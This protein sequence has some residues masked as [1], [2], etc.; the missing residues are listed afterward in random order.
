M[1]ADQTEVPV[2]RPDAD[3]AYRLANMFFLDDGNLALFNL[4]MEVGSGML[5]YEV[6][7]GPA[8]VVEADD[9]D[10]ALAIGMATV[11]P[12]PCWITWVFDDDHADKK[13]FLMGLV[14]GLKSVSQ[15][16]KLLDLERPPNTLAALVACEGSDGRFAYALFR[17]P[18]LD[19]EQARMILLNSF[20]PAEET[21]ET[22][23]PPAD[24]N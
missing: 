2:K 11:G 1:Q 23:G 22:P 18:I 15:P 19:E 9:T 4:V 14:H 13:D 20:P 17:H 16:K 3:D 5:P 24:K 7:D 6:I 8:D 12:T 10:I 21:E